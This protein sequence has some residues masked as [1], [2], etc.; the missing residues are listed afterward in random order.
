MDRNDLASDYDGLPP[1]TE[2][3]GTYYSFDDQCKLVNPEFE[4]YKK[5]RNVAHRF[6]VH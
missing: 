6:V 1:P 3:P 2:Y 5:V 4:A